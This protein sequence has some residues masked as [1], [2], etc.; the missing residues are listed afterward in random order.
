[1]IIQT[2]RGGPRPMD[3]GVMSSW[4]VP[5]TDDHAVWCQSISLS[6][7]RLFS[8]NE[9]RVGWLWPSSAQEIEL[10]RTRGKGR[11]VVARRSPE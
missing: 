10:K 2:L 7:R 11:M 8:L 5:G 3:A 4:I 1:M 6:M 9:V